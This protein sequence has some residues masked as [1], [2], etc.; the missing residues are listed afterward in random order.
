MDEGEDFDDMECIEEENALDETMEPEDSADDQLSSVE[1]VD[2]DELKEVFAAGW[3]A[4]QKTAEATWMVGAG[5][6]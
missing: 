5:Y 4:K 2:E 3:K 6:N 1:D